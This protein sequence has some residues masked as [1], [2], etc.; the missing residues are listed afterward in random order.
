M[1]GPD[2]Y[3]AWR[4]RARRR[5]PRVA[6][7][8]IDGGADDEVTLRRNRAAFEELSLVPRVL[9]G[10]EEASAAVDL[11]GQSL[12]LPV[13]LAPAG[14]ARLV[15]PRGELGAALGAGAAGTI[16][17]L[18]STA[19]V[20]A[21]SV[22]QAVAE[23]QWFQLYLFHDRVRTREVVRLA[24]RLGFS[25]LMVT[26]DAPVVGNRER[27]HRNGMRVPLRLSARMLAGALLRPR[28]LRHYWTTGPIGPHLA[29][30][31]LN[32]GV[33]GHEIKDHADYVRTLISPRQTWEDIEW[34][35]ELWDGP[36]LLKGVLSAADAER[37]LAAGCDGVVVS[38]H[39]GRQVDGAPASIEVLPEIVGAVGGRGEILLDSG[40]R[41]GTDVVKALCLGA[42]ACLIGRPW[43]YGLAA[44]GEPGVTRV[45]EQLHDEITRT[46]RLVGAASFD[47]LGPDL[48]RRRAIGG[49]QPLAS[50]AEL[51]P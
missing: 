2:N 40:V 33:D 18:A 5:L 16:A 47:D 10:V 22:A 39:G 30:P 7:D 20:S 25:A 44:G 45:L 29:P 42:R 24:A 13:L 12:R 43:W 1:R 32:G 3:D 31:S 8:F 50:G 51:S 49:W 35:R 36:L 26:V 6:F 41:R 48:V 46:M 15:H 11:F 28:W 27:D 38:N 4:K 14:N 19:S 21:E 9:R 23:P 37:A 17:V 34:I